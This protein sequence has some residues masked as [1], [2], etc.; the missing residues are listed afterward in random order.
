[1]VVP[2]LTGDCQCCV[3]M[4][5]LCVFVHMRHECMKFSFQI[6]V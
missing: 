3:C 1:M 2:E 5:V 6:G 4:Y